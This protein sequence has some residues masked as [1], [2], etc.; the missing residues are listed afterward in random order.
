V[1]LLPE[2]IT[3]NIS[4]KQKELTIIKEDIKNNLFVEKNIIGIYTTLPYSEELFSIYKYLKFDV[5][6]FSNNDQLRISFSDFEQ[7]FYE[8]QGKTIN[9]KN[10][11]EI[12]QD[13]GRIPKKENDFYVMLNNI[14]KG[15][16]ID[17]IKDNISNE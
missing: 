5:I 17:I 1:A 7:K 15:E 6:I 16:L 3:K 14:E 12:L 4:K 8:I 11:F 13:Y 2:N 10:I 9:K